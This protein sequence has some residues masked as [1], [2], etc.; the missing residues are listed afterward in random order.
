MPYTLQFQKTDTLA[1]TM[2][3]GATSAT[4]TSGNFGSPSGTQVLVID[5]DVPS[6]AAAFKCTIAGTALT[7]MVRVHGPDVEH[8]TGAKVTMAWVPEHHERLKDGTDIATGAIDGT[9]LSTSAITLGYASTTTAQI[10]INAETDLTG[11]SVDVTVPPGGRRVKITGYVP[12]V[13]YNFGGVAAIFIY[14]GTTQLGRWKF[15]MNATE[16]G[17]GI[18]IAVITPTSG[19]HT[20]KLRA[21]GANTIDTD[22]TTDSPAFILVEAI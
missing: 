10:G 6:K 11:L 2:G 4:L 8:V 17:L 1:S 5:Y 13:K 19:P 3:T 22:P 21:S 14:E 20:Y 15:Y 12:F 9:K 7:S 18:P 16:A